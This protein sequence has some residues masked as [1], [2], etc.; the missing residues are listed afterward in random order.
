M[1]ICGLQ[2]LAMVDYPD[3]LAATIFT[4]GCNLRC[5]FCH[6]ALLVTRLEESPPLDE[7]DIFAFLRSRRGLLEGVVLTGG[8]PL[9][10][11]DAAAFLSRVR[12][13]GFAVKLDTNGCFPEALAKILERGLVDY[14]AM[15][16]KNSPER[17][18]ETVGVPGFDLSPIEESI[19]L[20][21]HSGVDYE[22]RT[23]VVREL[24]RR[25]DL[26]SIADWIGGAP[27]YALQRF[28]DSGGLICPD[29]FHAVSEEEMHAWA[30]LLRPHFGQVVLRGLD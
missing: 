30:D 29:R 3:K 7:E 9:L 25:E 15:D 23:T 12:A 5:P 19:R 26:L 18:G 17:Y 11:L 1:R 20:L 8:E 22:F 13:L 14:V 28:V 10:Q 27:R 21:R 24:H 16:I 4:G 2:K 6:N